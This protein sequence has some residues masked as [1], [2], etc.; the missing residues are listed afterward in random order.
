M[1]DFNMADDDNERQSIGS[2]ASGGADTT[3]PYDPR[4]FIG[5]RTFR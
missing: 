1:L 4:R 5:D 2:K 3:D